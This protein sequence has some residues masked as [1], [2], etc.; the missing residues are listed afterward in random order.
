MIVPKKNGL[1][2]WRFK[3]IQNLIISLY[4]FFRMNINRLPDIGF[5]AQYV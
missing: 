5:V 2:F 1:K 3:G 4:M